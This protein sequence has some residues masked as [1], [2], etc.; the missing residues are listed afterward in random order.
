MNLGVFISICFVPQGPIASFSSSEDDKACTCKLNFEK[1]HPYRTDTIT[2]RTYGISPKLCKD[3][4]QIF[5]DHVQAFSK[6]NIILFF[7]QCSIHYSSGS[8][9]YTAK[10][11]TAAKNNMAEEDNDKSDREYAISTRNRL[12]ER[13][14]MVI[15]FR[16]L[17]MCRVNFY[18]LLQPYSTS[19]KRQRRNFILSLA[20]QII[21]FYL[22]SRINSLYFHNISNQ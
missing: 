5:F 15:S 3:I 6:L 13:R 21:Q 8:H 19:P 22:K 2:G 11:V 12:T 1:N 20:D 9:Y 18:I 14:Q 10:H 7:L 17:E 4:S 16:V